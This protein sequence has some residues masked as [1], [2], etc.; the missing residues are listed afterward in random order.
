MLQYDPLTLG[1]LNVKFTI[2]K[3]YLVDAFSKMADVGTKG[4]KAEYEKA[5]RITMKVEDKK[6]VFC[7]SNGFLDARWEVT[8]DTD[9]GLKCEESGEATV[10]VAVAHKIAEAIGGSKRDN[11][12]SVFVKGDASPSLYMKDASSKAKKIANMET[13][14][15]NHNS[16]IPKPR[17]SEFSYEFDAEEFI[18]GV[19]IISKYVART[20]Y[21]PRYR[22]ICLHFL[23][24]ETR[25]VCGDG[26]CFG[27]LSFTLDEE[28]K[29]V[30]D[31]AGHKFLMP[32]DQAQIVAGLCGKAKHV[33][34]AYKDRMTC[35]IKPLNGDDAA[36]TLMLKGIPN[37][38]YIS[39]DKHAFNFDD[40][41]TVVDLEKQDFLEGMQ[42]IG[43]VK[44]KE[45]LNK[46][47]FHAC[48]FVIKDSRAEFLVEDARFQADYDMDAMVHGEQEY[49]SCYAHDYLT[50]LAQCSDMPLVRFYCIDPQRTMIAEPADPT[51]NKKNDMGVPL[52]KEQNPR[53]SFFFAAAL[54][55]E[56]EDE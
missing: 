33:Q 42:L 3:S 49:A 38:Q 6:V 7:S 27:I 35:Y 31:D 41:K 28:N 17:T 4:I 14:P 45:K 52:N 18:K 22:M 26:S 20:N 1:D 50:H 12:I 48:D 10:D 23:K 44:D 43:A 29:D 51:D 47:G 36:L 19:N 11:L 46:E 37:D 9:S 13:I 8:T 56:D 16:S 32:C 34:I 25:F 15:E 39:Y 24:N 54:E 55:E 2:T 21:M 53:L 5:Y 30:Q 40:A